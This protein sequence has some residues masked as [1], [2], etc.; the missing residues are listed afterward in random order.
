MD[1]LLGTPKINKII[2]DYFII[3]CFILNKDVKLYIQKKICQ[4]LFISNNN[5]NNIV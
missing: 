2:F 4:Q 5:N 1:Q 3:N